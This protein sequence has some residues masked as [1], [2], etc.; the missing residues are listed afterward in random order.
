VSQQQLEA[1]YD[2]L[3]RPSYNKNMPPV[4]R[5]GGAI[6]VGVGVNFVKLK[7]FDVVSGTLTLVVHLRLCW[8]DDRLQFNSQKAFRS[9]WNSP[10]DRIVL[11]SNLVWNPDVVFLNE[12]DGRQFR[13]DGAP[14]L[15]TDDRFLEKT[16]VNVLWQRPLEIETKCRA[17]LSMFPFDSQSCELRIG[18]WATSRQYLQLEPQQLYTENNIHTQEFNMT[19]VEVKKAIVQGNVSLE[20]FDQVVFSLQFQRFAHYHVIHFILPMLT[21]TMMAIGTMWMGR[22][23]VGPRVNA[24]M[25]MVLAVLT[26]SFITAR[27]RPP[28]GVDIWLDKFQTHCFLLTVVSVAEGMMVDFI[29]DTKWCAYCLSVS[30]LDRLGRVVVVSAAWAVVEWDFSSVSWELEQR[31]RQTDGITEESSDLLISFVQGVLYLLAAFAASSIASLFY[32]LLVFARKW[33]SHQN[34]HQ[35]QELPTTVG[36]AV[37]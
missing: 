35:H 11:N 7:S 15:L 27:Q 2:D 20:Y 31:G 8:R 32:E 13:H 5:S 6:N 22:D 10:A 33:R 4:P 24:G 23:H 36:K 16:G 28:V 19:D 34:A 29:G 12:V 1:L 14:L 9:S 17:D 26:V 21:V 30:V 25:K 3:L 18:S 37:V